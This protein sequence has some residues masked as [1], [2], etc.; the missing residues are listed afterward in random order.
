MQIAEATIS[1]GS[2]LALLADRVVNSLSNTSYSDYD[3]KNFSK[4]KMLFDDASTGYQVLETRK[5]QEKAL[6]QLG[7]YSFTLY[8]YAALSQRR[9]DIRKHD[10][11][12]VIIDLAKDMA[13]LSKGIAPKDKSRVK[14]LIEF[15]T[16]MRNISLTSNIA[17]F[18]KVIIGNIG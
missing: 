11:K 14:L 17:G 9:R 7:A 1:K 4:A 8:T 13:N 3:K 5:L 10:I 18:D 15:F 2:Q 12:A 16:I 6:D